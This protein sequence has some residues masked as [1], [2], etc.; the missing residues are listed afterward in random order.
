[1]QERN[2]QGLDHGAG[3]I[4][5]RCVQPMAK[6]TYSLFTLADRQWEH[7]SSPCGHFYMT[8]R[9]KWHTAR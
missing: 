8:T 2:S 9:Q 5:K 1:M 4:G 7:S 6:Q 3:G